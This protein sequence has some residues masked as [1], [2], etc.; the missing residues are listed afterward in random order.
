VAKS[1]GIDI[2]GTFIDLVVSDESGLR[3][4]KFSSTPD[5][6]ERGVLQ[7]LE[8]LI[9]RRVFDPSSVSRMAHGST[10]ATNALL[11]GAWAKTALITTRGF[12]DVLEIGRQ[13]RSDLYNLNVERPDPIIPRDLR[14][15]SSERLDAAGQ[16]VRDVATDEIH[17]IADQLVA[18]DVEAVAVV[19]LFSYLNPEHERA[20]LDLLHEKMNV[21]I[22]LSSDVLPEFREYERSST[23]AVC[24]SLRPVI[25]R[26]I[27]N[28][29]VQSGEIGIA[30]E[31]QIMQSN[32]TVISATQAQ[33]EPVRI[34]LSGPAAG[35]QGAKTIGQMKKLSN[36]ITM[37]MGGTS[38]DVALIREG[39][40]G[41]TTTGAVGE[42]PVAVRMNEIHTIGAGGGS[43]AWID[44]GGALRVGPRSA[45]AAPGPACY[46]RGGILPTVSDAH[47]VLGHLLPD[48]PLGGL[49]A[50]DIDK[51][52]DAI[53]SIAAPLSLSIEEGALGI[54]DVADAAMERAVRVISVERGYDPRQFSLLA[55]GGA[56]PLHAVSIARRLSIPSVIIPAAAGVLSAMGLLTCEAGRDY[57]RSILR[58]MSDLNTEVLM[59]Q[60]AELE[61]RSLGE[62]RAE[63]VEEESVRREISADLRYQGQSHELNIRLLPSSGFEISPLDLDTW[64]ESFHREHEERFG[65]ASRDEGVELVALRLRMTAPPT[66][67][68]P[69]VRFDG[70]AAE[71][72][73]V[74]VWFDTGGAVQAQIIDRRGLLENERI[75]GPA[76]L[77]GPD[78]TLLVPP[79]VEG[80]CDAMGT[81]QLE[82]S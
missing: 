70:K 28:L 57:G 74:P 2:G 61:S 53:Q 33:R 24:A 10:V 5:A 20:V 26:Y 63:G 4:Y 11:E 41:Q 16:V 18:A 64:V 34:L 7:A 52:R 44:P 62:L 56:G 42:H 27:K 45:G 25:E 3:L 17:E 40:I 75:I 72:Q 35:V 78:A 49:P 47:V 50:L 80:A 22:T 19:F 48:M 68:H 46:G 8:D 13:N 67:S 31:W 73:E 32:G 30:P 54:L 81:I 6:P 82:T 51:A 21:P 38:C 39:E 9:E 23:T 55:F 77:W 65:H 58:Q 12:R 14:F 29:A 71:R 59:R 1:I 36:L 66:F 43:I 37:D 76:V 60:L 15:E 69:C 79:G